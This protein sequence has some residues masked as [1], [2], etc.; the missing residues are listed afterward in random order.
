MNRDQKLIDVLYRARYAFVTHGGLTVRAEGS[1]WQMNF[2]KQIAEI[3]EALELLGS[4]LRS[5][6]ADAGA[7][8]SR[9]W[10]T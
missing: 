6:Q 2:A 4:G 1:E 9:R 3:D 7:A 10:V 8:V 5:E